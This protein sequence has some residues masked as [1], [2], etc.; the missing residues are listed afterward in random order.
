LHSEASAKQGKAKQSKARQ[1]GAPACKRIATAEMQL[2]KNL[3][4]KFAVQRSTP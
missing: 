1:K 4:K 3:L 2:P